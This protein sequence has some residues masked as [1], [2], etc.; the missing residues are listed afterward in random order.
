MP[1]AYEENGRMV[2][3]C[4]KCGE[5]KGVEEFGKKRRDKKLVRSACTKC[6]TEYIREW[7]QKRY[8]EC[9][10]YRERMLKRDYERKRKLYHEC[11]EY[12]ELMSR[13]NMKN[14]SKS[15]K[16]L[17]DSYVRKRIRSLKGFYLQK[18]EIS[19]ELMDIYR[20]YL[21]AE[22]MRRDGERSVSQ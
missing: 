22:R 2:K 8:H 15:V 10:E 9:Q 21:Q 12:R 7:K 1:K 18:E 11:Q 6:C 3:K 19:S 4:T 16:N 20:L 5:V 13:L 17:T 14:S